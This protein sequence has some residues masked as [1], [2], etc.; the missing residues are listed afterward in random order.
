MFLARLPPFFCVEYKNDFRVG[1]K[2]I[3]DGRVEATSEIRETFWRFW[4][5]YCKPLVIDPYLEE[6][7]FQTKTR[8]ATG[9]AGRVPKVSHGPG[10]QV[11]VG[12]VR[13]AIRGVNAKISLDTGQKPLH[14]PGSNDRYILPLQ[15]MLKG[16]ENKDLPLLKKLA[17]HND[18]PDW[19]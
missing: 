2:G 10:K 6:V 4:C 19:M 17:V 8:V 7:N 13:A 15:Y 18:L 11:Q 12:T 16:F 3:S 14:Q 5:A 1:Y 9:F